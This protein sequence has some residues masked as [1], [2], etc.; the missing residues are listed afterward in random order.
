MSE[1][2]TTPGQNTLPLNTQALVAGNFDEGA[3][4]KLVTGIDF[5]VRIQLCGASANLCK[6]GKIGVGNYA[7]MKNKTEFIDLGKSV[8]AW[9]CGLRMKALDFGGDPVTVYYDPKS[10]EFQDILRRADADKQNSGCLAGFEFL[11][12]LPDV[13]VA[14]D[15]PGT[16]VTFFLCSASARNE[17]PSFRAYLGK[18]VTLSSKLAE[19]KKKQKWHV[20]QALACSLPLGSPNTDELQAVVN[21]FVNAMPSSVKKAEAAAVGADAD[22][23]Q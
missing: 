21:R 4:G 1:A 8:N 17:A 10:A 2:L 7:L 14:G 23:P 20:P 15:K 3:A 19:N 6:E 16:Y 18:T 11:L 22:R 13:K 5:L 12:Y 9:V